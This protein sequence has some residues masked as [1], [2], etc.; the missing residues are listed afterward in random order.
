MGITLLMLPLLLLRLERRN[1][2]KNHTTSQLAPRHLP[3][4]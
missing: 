4:L 1:E 3:C 2:D